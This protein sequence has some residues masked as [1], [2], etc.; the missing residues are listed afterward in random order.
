MPADSLTTRR[1][2]RHVCCPLIFIELFPEQLFYNRHD[3]TS[4]KNRLLLR[5]AGSRPALLATVE[6][7]GAR[8]HPDRPALVT[9]D[10]NMYLSE[11]KV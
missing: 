8:H 11:C 10:G 3:V 6:F 5:R 9:M 4:R 1:A 2:N 7:F